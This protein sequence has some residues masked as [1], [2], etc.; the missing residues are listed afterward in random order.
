MM[1]FEFEHG[2]VWLI[3]GLMLGLIEIMVGTYYL[4]ALA[5]GA[6]LAG[7]MAL[8]VTMSWMSEM[9][10][11]S[12]ASMVSLAAL[13]R[14]KQEQDGKQC[15]ADD[16]SHLHGQRVIVTVRIAPDGRV[17]HKGV[18]WKA[19]SLMPFEVGE[20]AVI[21]RVNGSTLHVKNSDC[22]ESVDHVTY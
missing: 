6:L 8:I 4:L 19:E 3:L 18:E 14:W 15:P 9:I 17:R 10:V 7:I 13:L 11:F 20:T 12:I 5:G 16:V 2:Y 21:E 22:S 1:G